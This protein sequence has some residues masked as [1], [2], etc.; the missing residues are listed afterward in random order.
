[1]RGY[2]QRMYNKWQE[3]GP[4]TSTQQ[5]IADQARAIRKNGCLTNLE[6]EGIKR[7][8]LNDDIKEGQANVERHDLNLSMYSEESNEVNN[9]EEKPADDSCHWEQTR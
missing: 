6:L 1:M 7:K 9:I 2:R 5:R 3:I 8:V 4:F